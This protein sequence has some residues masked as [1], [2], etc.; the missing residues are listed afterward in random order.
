MAAISKA[1]ATKVG[2][3]TSDFLAEVDGRSL[4]ARRYNE[5]SSALIRDLGGDE[6]VGEAQRQLVRRATTIAVQAELME[7]GLANGEPFNLDAY[8]KGAN[9]LNRI[10]T[11]LGLRRHARDITPGGTVDAHAAALM[12]VPE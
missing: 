11:T 3:G 12:E 8:A 5:I 7:A 9:T 4:I 1:R 2:L 10:L 6:I